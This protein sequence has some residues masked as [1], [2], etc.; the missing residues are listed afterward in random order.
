MAN[1]QMHAARKILTN[2]LLINND[3]G[4]RA[5]RLLVLTPTTGYSFMGF[6]NKYNP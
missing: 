3:L 6:M 1:E 2:G 5:T 4:I